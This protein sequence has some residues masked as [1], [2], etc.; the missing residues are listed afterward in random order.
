VS[1]A[2]EPTLDLGAAAAEALAALGV[3]EEYVHAANGSS[4]RPPE[5]WKPIAGDVVCGVVVA[6]RELRDRYNHPYD[7]LIVKVVAGTLKGERIPEG[8]W[9]A[10]ACGPVVLRDWIERDNPQLGDKVTVFY[11]GRDEGQNGRNQYLAGVAE[12]AEPTST[13]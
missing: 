7:S 11:G 12:R 1:E 10:V 5:R 9:A 6:R 4:T 13:W 3:G 2:T 8:D